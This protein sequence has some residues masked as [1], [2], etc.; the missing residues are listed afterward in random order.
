MAGLKKR[1]SL[2][3]EKEVFEK[4]WTTILA[5]AKIGIIN[6]QKTYVCMHRL[7]IIDCK[8]LSIPYRH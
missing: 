1:L 6:Q 4:E 8:L 7:N 3:E 5:A 2:Q